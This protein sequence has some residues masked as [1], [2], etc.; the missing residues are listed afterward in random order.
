MNLRRNATIPLLAAVCALAASLYGPGAALAATPQNPVLADCGAHPGGLVGNYTV[1]Q[2]RHALQIMPPET[3]EYTSCPD[4]VNRALLAALGKPTSGGSS[5]GGGGSGSFLPTPVIVVLVVLALA[6]ITFGAL[7]IRRRQQTGGA[8]PGRG[9]D[10]VRRPSGDSGQREPT[11]EPRE[12]A[13]ESQNAGDL[14]D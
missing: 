1:Q 11:D 9:P 7:A 14:G 13:G 4:V 2:L 5:S 8:A 6:A 10:A 12:P 3:R